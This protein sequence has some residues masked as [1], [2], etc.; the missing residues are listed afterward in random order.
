MGIGF[1]FSLD[2]V[3]GVVLQSWRTLPKHH[4]RDNEK[5]PFYGVLFE[6]SKYIW[7]NEKELKKLIN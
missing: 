7:Y 1:R 2:G 5:G 3:E 4:K 6:D